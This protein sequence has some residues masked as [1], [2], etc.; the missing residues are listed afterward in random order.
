MKKYLWLTVFVVGL[1]PLIS[2]AQTTTYSFSLVLEKEHTFLDTKRRS[3]TDDIGKEDIFGRNY[4]MPTV[5]DVALA[6]DQAEIHIDRFFENFASSKKPGKIN[7]GM[8]PLPALYFQSEKKTIQ[9]I[10]GTTGAKT[11]FLFRYNF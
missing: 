2:K 4:L 5:V 9:F 10:G 11:E 3:V 7:F 6:S 1:F 8:I